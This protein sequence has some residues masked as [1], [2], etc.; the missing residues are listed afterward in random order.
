MAAPE[1]PD[2]RHDDESRAAA[3]GTPQRRRE[4]DNAAA[5]T[6]EPEDSPWRSRLR[7]FRQPLIGLG[8]AGMALP[9]VQ[10]TTS[11]TEPA[12][13]GEADPEAARAAG[14]DTEEHLAGRI[15]Q[16]RE[17]QERMRHIETAVEKYGIS[18]ELAEDIF[19]I[20]REQDIEPRLAYG[21]VKTE[22]TF[23][24]R[25]VSHVGARGLTQ[26]MPRTAAWL[27][28]GTRTE[29]L[30]D[31]QTNLRLGFRYLNQMIDKYKGDVRLALLAY[32]RG[33]GTV[34]KVLKRGGNP[35]NGYADKVLRS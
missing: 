1:H 34:D 16:T 29:D 9:M 33:P 30:Y 32:N 2:R 8:L 11:E 6:A 7:R 26:V 23:D 4:D 3:A 22:S 18:R 21:L 15:A 31:R 14:A 17:Q 25:A 13:N 28:P 27:L 12:D 24:E 10:A 35:D 5:A 19:D 20:A